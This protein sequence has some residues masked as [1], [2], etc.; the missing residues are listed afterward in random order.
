MKLCI[1]ESNLIL[2]NFEL[3]AILFKQTC[4]N[5]SYAS[6]YEVMHLFEVT[7]CQLIS[8]QILFF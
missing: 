7:W 1:L 2:K 6:F 3:D 5:C 8:F 4:S